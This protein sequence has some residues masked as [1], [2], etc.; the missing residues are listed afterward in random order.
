MPWVQAH[1]QVRG[2]SHQRARPSWPVATQPATRGT[3]RTKPSSW[4]RSLSDGHA[5]AI[6]AAVVTSAG[7]GPATRRVVA[8]RTPTSRAIP[9]MRVQT[10]AS[11][12]NR[13]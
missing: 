13:L 6:T 12:P 10:T 4:G 2:T 8:S 3:S 7:A 1:S 9:T 5:A 11:S